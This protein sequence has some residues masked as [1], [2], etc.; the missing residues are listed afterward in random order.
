MTTPP[1]T[2]AIH[3]RLLERRAKV[4]PDA[5]SLGKSL[6]TVSETVRK[7]LEEEDYLAAKG[8]ALSRKRARGQSVLAE[9]R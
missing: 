6:L 9:H 8:D 5:K 2:A 3:I 7:A 4:F 1:T